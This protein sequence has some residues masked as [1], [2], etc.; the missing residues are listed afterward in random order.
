[1]ATTA[2]IAAT[3][4][5]IRSLLDRALADSTEFNTVNASHYQAD[6]LQGAGKN[7][8]DAVSVYLHR[9]TVS[10]VRRNLPPGV[11]RAG[12]RVR[13]PIP[14]DL[15]YLISAWGKSPLA[16]QALLGFSI[17]T[18]EDT[19]ILPP[20]LL[21]EGGY[22]GVFRADETVEL[23]WTPLSVQDE[24]DVWQVAQ[25]SQQP[26]AHYIARGVEIESRLAYDELPLVQTREFD[27]G[28]VVS[29]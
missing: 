27:V 26:S 29:P 28:V 22:A 3:S 1:M 11:G 21:N 16:Q 4:E 6:E 24:A 13:P 25:T 9:V 23:V 10:S 7:T 5:A 20:T 18:L 12:E 15:Y 17:R 14:V 8:A 19:P 2:A